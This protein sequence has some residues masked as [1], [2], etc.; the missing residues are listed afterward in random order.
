VEE[1]KRLNEELESFA[2]L[3]PHDLRAP[4]RGIKGF[5]SILLEKKAPV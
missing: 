4:L 2:C 1:V 5:A 3:V